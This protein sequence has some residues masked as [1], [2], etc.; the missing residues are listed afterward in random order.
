VIDVLGVKKPPALYAWGDDRPPLGTW[1]RGR[2]LR[3]MEEGSK[4]RDM[5]VL[6]KV[7]SPQREEK[8]KRNKKYV[9]TRAPIKTRTVS[10]TSP[11]G[12]T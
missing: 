12:S 9:R 3:A 6:V 2:T 11:G 7:R 10:D 5:K 8:K 4:L 1:A